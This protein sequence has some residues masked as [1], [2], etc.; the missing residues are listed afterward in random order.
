MYD[1][2]GNSNTLRPIIMLR[3]VINYNK[4]IIVLPGIQIIVII[5]ITINTPISPMNDGSLSGFLMTNIWILYLKSFY[6][7]HTIPFLR[8]VQYVYLF[9]AN[10]EKIMI[11]L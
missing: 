10:N 9:Y 6:R 11:Q 1:Y 7:N 5:I 8:T 3:Y 2:N 4:I